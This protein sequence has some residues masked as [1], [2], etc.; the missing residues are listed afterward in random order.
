M[1][2][3]IFPSLGFDN[4]NCRLKI[5]TLL[6]KLHEHGFHSWDFKED[7]VAVRDGEYRLIDFHK[8]HLHE[9]DWRTGMDWCADKVYYD[10]IDAISCE[11]LVN[12]ADDMCLW[13][14][15]EHGCYECN[16]LTTEAP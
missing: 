11:V 2:P 16:V 3:A 8:M 5:M 7:N 12:I 15:C 9:C 10:A 14:Y 6:G 13:K 1:S 4:H